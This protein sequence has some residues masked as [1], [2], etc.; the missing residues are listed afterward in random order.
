[1]KIFEFLSFL[2]L[3]CDRF[4]FTKTVKDFSCME[5]SAKSFNKSFDIVQGMKMNN[6]LFIVLGLLDFMRNGVKLIAERV[7]KIVNKFEI[8]IFINVSN[9]KTVLNDFV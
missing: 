3:D 2:D 6:D 9:D 1:M 4:S 5:M 7:F 8:R